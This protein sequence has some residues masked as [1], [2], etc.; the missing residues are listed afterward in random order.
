MNL[1][2][3]ADHNEKTIMFNNSF[4]IL[5]GYNIEELIG[6]IQYRIRETTGLKQKKRIKT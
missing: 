5:R 3:E 2:G 1:V 4:A 6:A